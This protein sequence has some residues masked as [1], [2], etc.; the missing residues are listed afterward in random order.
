MSRNYSSFFSMGLLTL[1]V[2]AGWCHLPLQ[3]RQPRR[4]FDALSDTD[5]AFTEP[6]DEI[7]VAAAET[8]I[9]TNVHVKRGD[10]VVPGDLLIE[11]DMSVLEAARRIAEAKAN[12]IAKRKAAE[13][14]YEI[15]QARH[16]K[17]VRLRKEGAGS[18]EEVKRA[19]A[20]TEVARQ[21]ISAL[22][23]E[24]QL[25]QLEVKQHE[26]QM[27][28]RRIR[29]PIHGQ[30]VDIKKRVGEHVSGNDPHMLT[31]VQLNR[32][33]VTFYVTTAK[34]MNLKA[35]DF[36]KVLL[37]ETRQSAHAQ[38]EFIAPITHAD[39]G[40][41]RMDVLIDNAKGQYRS[42]VRCRLVE[43]ARAAFSPSSN[44]R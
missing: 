36:I 11:L 5:E 34:A 6:I 10:T 29:S 2:L 32:L 38:I 23:E 16:E 9:V 20:D 44:Q 42:G 12:N 31:V 18:P 24:A 4:G 3:D 13:I 27:E 25:Y 28:R 15:K 26:A 30:V 35:G 19:K 33:R 41:V 39:S 7:K 1:L 43:S 17:L 21:N 14:E 37:P 8:G 40:R 22:V